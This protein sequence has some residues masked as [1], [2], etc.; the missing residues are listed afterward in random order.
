MAPLDFFPSGAILPYDMAQKKTLEKL[1]GSSPRV[2]LLRLFLASPERTFTLVEVVRH[3]N[4]DKET[5]RRQL[6]SLIDIGL[7]SEKNHGKK[8]SKNK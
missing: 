1:L 7:V 4:V 6:R 5:V 2:R 3:T 8:E